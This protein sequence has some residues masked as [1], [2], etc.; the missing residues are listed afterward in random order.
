MWQYSF[1]K[2]TAER[3]IRAMASTLLSLW[4]VGNVALNALSIDWRQALGI[5]LGAAIVSILT[6]LAATQATVK[7][8][9]SF[10]TTA[11]ASPNDPKGP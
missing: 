7:G 4:L 1:W 9:A 10:V 3:A 11:S 8:T 6:S 5:A 2:D